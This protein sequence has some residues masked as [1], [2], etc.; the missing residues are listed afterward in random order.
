MLNLYNDDELT[1]AEAYLYAMEG[2]NP[3]KAIENQ[4]RRGQQYV[5]MHSRIPVKSNEISVPDAYRFA[6]VENGMPYEQRREIVDKN[7]LKYTNEQY[8]RMGIKILS[9]DDL[10]YDV[11]LPEGWKVEA[12]DHSMWNNLVDDK[13]RVRATFF[14]K[15]AF[16]DR[17]AFINFNTRYRIIAEHVADPSSE[18][19]VWKMSDYQGRVYD[20]D[21]I[22]YH[23]P[24]VPAT[25]DYSKDDEIQKNL[26]EDLKSYMDKNYPDYKDIHAYWN[27]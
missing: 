26:L 6:G 20:G 17:D 27:D 9:F 16:Y 15:A 23:T 22:I 18:Y 10:F 21:T 14:Y 25:G 13:G 4:E 24:S 5:V 19:E 12:T 8:A 1:F 7:N 2:K 11:E 3:S